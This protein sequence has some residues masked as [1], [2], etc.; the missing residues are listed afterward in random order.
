MEH[1]IAHYRGG[2]YL[3]SENHDPGRCPRS[4]RIGCHR[5]IR[6]QQPHRH[7]YQR[8]NPQKKFFRL[9]TFLDYLPNQS[10]KAL[11]TSRNRMAALYLDTDVRLLSAR[12][13]CICWN[14]FSAFLHAQDYDLIYLSRTYTEKYDAADAIVA[15]DISEEYFH[16]IGDNNFSPLLALDCR[17]GDPL[18]LK[19]IPIMHRWQ[20]ERTRSFPA[21]PIVFSLSH[22]K[23]RE[24]IL[25]R[26][27]VSE[28]HYV[29]SLRNWH[30]FPAEPARDG[31]HAVRAA[32]VHPQMSATCHLS[33]H[34]SS[35]VLFCMNSA[36]RREPLQQHAIA[37]SPS[38]FI[39]RPPSC[40]LCGIIQCEH[41]GT[42]LRC[43]QI[44]PRLLSHGKGLSHPRRQC[45]CS[46]Y[47][48]PAAA[49]IPTVTMEVN[50]NSSP[51]RQIN[52]FKVYVPSC[53]VNF[54][55]SEY[56]HLY[57]RYNRTHDVTICLKIPLAFSDAPSC[58]VH[59]IVSYG[60]MLNASHLRHDQPR[61]F[62]HDRGEI[63]EVRF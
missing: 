62:P 58:S 54:V 16:Q 23:R 44:P 14:V 50:T 52:L 40:L 4:R 31:S 13:R 42:A 6:D 19:S 53:S 45:L 28:V 61:V 55:S 38:C 48:V 20:P 37:V 18:F 47:S 49:G 25:R 10:A 34:V 3:E 26:R 41:I 2:H 5:F 12:S 21:S 15:Y 30:R 63:P 57:I 8:C 29:N 46:G 60:L 39:P 17:I 7:A 33:L 59:V 36:L 22:V 9:S 24:E 1:R 43:D 11:A 32:R 51:L 27:H 56:T 35:Q